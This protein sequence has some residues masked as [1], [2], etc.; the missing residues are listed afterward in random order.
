MRNRHAQ[1]C[2]LASLP[3]L[4][5]AA[6]ALLTTGA[7]GL[8]ATAA[9]TP[10]ATAILAMLARAVLTLLG[11]RAGK[12]SSWLSSFMLFHQNQEVISPPFGPTVTAEGKHD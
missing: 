8:L 3:L 11:E 9:L 5:T 7:L 2:L 6:L 1:R 4:A 12:G 10:L